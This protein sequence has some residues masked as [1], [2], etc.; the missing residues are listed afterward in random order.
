V[1]ARLASSQPLGQ[2]H[3]GLAFFI[4]HPTFNYLEETYG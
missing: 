1:L 3:P 2:A 4:Y